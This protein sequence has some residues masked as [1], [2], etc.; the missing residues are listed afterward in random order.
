MEGDKNHGRGR[1]EE[2]RIFLKEKRKVFET[3]KMKI[4]GKRQGIV[5]YFL[6]TRPN[7][8]I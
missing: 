5:I 4:K 8:Q 7:D 1:K 3:F 2:K 6:L